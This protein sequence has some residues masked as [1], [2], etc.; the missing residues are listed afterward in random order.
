MISV[1]PP[2]STLESLKSEMEDAKSRGEK[3]V[4]VHIIDIQSLINLAE[5]NRWLVKYSETP[6]DEAKLV[7][8]QESTKHNARSAD[9]VELCYENFR[10]LVNLALLGIKK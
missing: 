3:K 9:G 10:E 1:S 7:S 4:L 6:L 5:V 2:N 8:W